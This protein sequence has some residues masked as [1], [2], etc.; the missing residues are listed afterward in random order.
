MIC[1]CP[2][3]LRNGGAG[4]ESRKLELF[5][6]CHSLCLAHSKHSVNNRS[7]PPLQEPAFTSLEIQN[8]RRYLTPPFS[9]EVALVTGQI[10]AFSGVVRKPVFAAEAEEAVVQG[11]GLG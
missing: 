1:M 5:A 8:F 3:Q 2:T 11:S 6:L 7:F 10:S 4:L 9:L